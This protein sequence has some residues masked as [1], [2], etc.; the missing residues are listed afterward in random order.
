MK[1]PIYFYDYRICIH[2]G[3][4]KVVPIN[5]YGKVQKVMIYPITH[6]MCNECKTQYFIKWIE[7]EEGDIVPT[8]CGDNEKQKIIEE[9]S[10]FAKNTRR[11]L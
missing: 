9:I 4:N 6:M 3:S 2:C 11:E 8:C 5:K 1:Y 7:N 10:S